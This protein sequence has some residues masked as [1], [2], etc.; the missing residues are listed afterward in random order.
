MLK[1]QYFGH[2]MQRA[3]SLEN[4]LMLG[5]TEGK[6]RKGQPTGDEMV[7]WHHLLNGH[8]SKQTLRYREFGGQGS[9]ECCIPWDRKGSDTA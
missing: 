3:N 7:G 5:N 9:L 4:T 2:L 6:S 1:L 8:E